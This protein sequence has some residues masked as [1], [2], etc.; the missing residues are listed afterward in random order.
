MTRLK[1]LKERGLAARE[2]RPVHILEDGRRL[3]AV[4]GDDPAAAGWRPAGWDYDRERQL[5]A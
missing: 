5:T 2:R 4:L 3:W 1:D